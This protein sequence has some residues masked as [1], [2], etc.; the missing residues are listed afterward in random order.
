M[1]IA[2]MKLVTACLVKAKPKTESTLDGTAEG[3]SISLLT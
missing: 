1:T 3:S 2:V